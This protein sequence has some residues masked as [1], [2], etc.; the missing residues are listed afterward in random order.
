MQENAIGPAGLRE[1]A[2]RGRHAELKDRL[3]GISQGLDRLR[4][5][6]HQGYGAGAGAG[7]SGFPPPPAGVGAWAAHG[8]CTPACLRPSSS[9]VAQLAFRS[10]PV[11]SVV[12]SLPFVPHRDSGP[13]CGDGS[14]RSGSDTRAASLAPRVHPVRGPGPRARWPPHW[15]RSGRGW[16]LPEHPAARVRGR[17]P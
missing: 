17:P 8:S 10:L 11:P 12:V 2:L 9:E 7:E 15:T 4:R 5:V 1:E 14:T 16:V 3:R 13:R 6:S